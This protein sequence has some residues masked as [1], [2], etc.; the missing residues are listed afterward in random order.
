LRTWQTET[1]VLWNVR[2]AAPTAPALEA[3]V[4]AITPDA[5]AAWGSLWSEADR[6][7][8]GPADAQLPA[9]WAMRAE[10]ALQAVRVPGWSP[11][12]LLSPRHLFPVLVIVA[13]LAPA[14]SLRADS[15]AEAYRRGDFA[16]AE[17]G[18]RDAVTA[19]P[20]DWPA[21]H[22]LGLALAQ[23]DR[24]AEATAHWTS[25]FLLQPQSPEV[26]ADLALGLQRSGLA[27]AELVAFSRGE[28]RHAL[29]RAASPGAWQRL[30]YAAAALIAAGGALFL[31]QVYRRI[32]SWGR[33]AA[34]AA[35]ILAIGVAA[36]ATLSLHTYGVLAEPGAVIVWK[37]STLRSVPTEADT[38]KTTALSAGSIAVA[39]RTFLGW[40]RLNFAGGQT[41]WARTDDL[42]PLYR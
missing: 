15:P 21:R 22:N 7:L 35:V 20:H 13:A 10:A 17:K 18:W 40:T 39:D 36:P 41:G 11:L 2:H 9:D 12:S 30:L 14:A 4:A 28:G 19:A 37:P 26:R 27:P 6:S 16:V 38:Q 23:Q 29:A 32:G 33:P 5:A 25:A 34:L 31:L 3:A 24:W 42:L 8:H 1:A